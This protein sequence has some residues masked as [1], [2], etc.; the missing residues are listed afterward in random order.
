M[1]QISNENLNN[2]SLLHSLAYGKCCLKK[3]KKMKNSFLLQV[4]G[5]CSE[6]LFLF[7]FIVPYFTLIQGILWHS[8]TSNTLASVSWAAGVI[9]M[10]HC[11]WVHYFSHQSD[12]KEKNTSN[13][14]F[15]VRIPNQATMNDVSEPILEQQ[16][17]QY[18]TGQMQMTALLIAH[19]FLFSLST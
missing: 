4:F 1:I 3:R 7:N 16:C 11:T 18:L 8:Q 9:R 6:F 10:F 13:E 19:Q 12:I 15:R 17:V 2:S 5:L 14:S